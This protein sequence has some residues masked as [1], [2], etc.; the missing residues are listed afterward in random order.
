MVDFPVNHL[1]FVTGVAPPHGNCVQRRGSNYSVLN[2]FPVPDDSATCL[3]LRSR[4]RCK[5]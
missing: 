1:T 2:V 5:R 3:A 4:R